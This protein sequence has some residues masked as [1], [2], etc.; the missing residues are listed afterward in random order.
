MVMTFDSVTSAPGERK[1]S[2]IREIKVSWAGHVSLE[3]KTSGSQ[4]DVHI[5]QL[6]HPMFDINR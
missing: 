4:L 2:H 6:E 1:Y 3:K 5:S